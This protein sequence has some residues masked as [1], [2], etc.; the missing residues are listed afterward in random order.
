[1]ATAF[2]WDSRKERTNRLKH[3]VS[4]AEARTVFDDRLAKIFQDSDHSE[5][6]SREIIIGHS[7]TGRCY[8]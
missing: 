8:W 5:V 4:F 2:D 1:M 6:E 7:S 3:G